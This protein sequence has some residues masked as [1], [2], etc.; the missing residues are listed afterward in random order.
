M[1][2]LVVDDEYIIIAVCRKIL[3]G[4]GH[5]VLAVNEVGDAFGNLEKSSF[6]FVL[7]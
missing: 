1:R 2:T 5:E 6:D 3:E 7:K 4:E